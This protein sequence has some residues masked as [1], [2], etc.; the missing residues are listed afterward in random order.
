MLPSEENLREG[1]TSSLLLHSL[2]GHVGVG[3]VPPA[4]ADTFVEFLSLSHL[5][6]VMVNVKKSCACS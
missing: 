6:P 5:D 2:L 4:E 1:N 3:S